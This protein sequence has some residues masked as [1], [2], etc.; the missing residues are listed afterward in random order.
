MRQFRPSLHSYGITEQQWRVL[1]ALTTVE[2]I[3]VLELAKAT[4]LLPPSLSR[5][6]KDLEV[7]KLIIRTIS[8]ADLR[9]GIISIS[10]TGRA[11]IEAAGPVSEAIY[12]EIT[13]RFGSEKLKALHLLLDELEYCLETPIQVETLSKPNGRGRLAHSSEE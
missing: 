10:P 6:L 1:R 2:N 11:L 13:A 8:E 4:Y 9:R 12:S 5:I 7:R 3:E